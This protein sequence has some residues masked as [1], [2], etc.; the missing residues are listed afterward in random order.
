MTAAATAG[1]ATNPATAELCLGALAR[2]GAPRARLAVGIGWQWIPGELGDRLI[3]SGEPWPDNPQVITVV[4]RD[5]PA[6]ADGEL[7]A[8]VTGENCFVTGDRLE[9]RLYG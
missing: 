9:V 2:G 4:G 3:R 1:A 7:L 5:Q 6:P 8:V